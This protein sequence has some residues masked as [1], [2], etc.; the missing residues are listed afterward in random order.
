MASNLSTEQCGTPQ[1]VALLRPHKKSLFAAESG[2]A[3]LTDVMMS[4]RHCK[5]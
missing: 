3:E 5:V 2:R 1:C 4:Q